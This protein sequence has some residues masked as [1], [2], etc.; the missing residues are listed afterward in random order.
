MYLSKL[1]LKNFRKYRELEIP[2]KEGLN[3][4]IG[5]NDSGKTAIID[6]IRILM[7]TQSY[8]YYFIDE[9]DFN[10][11][12]KE[13]EIECTFSFKKESNDKVAKFLEWI[14]FNEK[15]EPKLIVRLKASIKDFKVKKVITAGEEGLDSRF[16][17]LDDLRVTYLKPLRDA[18]TELTAGR[19]SRLSQILKNHK[20]FVNQE[21]SHTF[22]DTIKSFNEE[23]NSYFKTGG[24]GESIISNINNHLDDFL[25]KERLADYNTDINITEDNL[26]SI[27]N[28]LNL[29]ISKNK[30]GLGTL[31]QLYMAL[32]L[33]LFETEN[34]PLNLCLIE[35]LEAHLHPQAQLRTI[36]HFQN[37]LNENSQII[38]TTHSIN[39]AS[40][41]KLE[42][43]ILCKNDNVYPMGKD[44]TELDTDDYE[45]LEIFLD[46]TKSN[47]FFAK[48][49][50]FVEGDAE[51]I[52]VPAIAEII[53]RPLHEYGVSIVNIGNV[54]FK[55]YSRIFLRKKSDE[56]IGIKVAII[57]DLDVKEIS[58]Y[59]GIVLNDEMLSRINKVLEQKGKNIDDFKDGIF[60]DEEELIEN[61]KEKIGIKRL[62][63]GIK[64]IIKNFEIVDI[65]I[66]IYRE[67]IKQR[68]EKI[69]NKSNIKV[70]LN[71]CQ[72]LEYDLAMSKI[73]YYLNNAILLTKEKEELTEEKFNEEY[74]K[75]NIKEK[76]RKIFI[77]NFYTNYEENK[78]SNLS[79]AN[80]ALNLSYILRQNQENVR[81]ILLKDDYCKY[82][83][84][85]I[86][87]VTAPIER[88]EIR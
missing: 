79:K 27:L 74:G 72:T 7:G 71:K 63:S 83:V 64:E 18:N 3:V 24:A 42:N 36:K 78:K 2:F 85:A 43:L 68:K 50:I 48:G 87:Y 75:D 6:S 51:N 5:E 21:N 65:D 12:N 60:R 66:E 17:L 77:E 35:E 8:E 62:Y 44:Y 52:L 55:R 13:L 84:D 86:E 37:K 61:I 33:L 22:L 88:E 30:V 16:D 45:F 58:N 1:K 76:A 26:S 56:D 14:T 73:A 31:N 9:K 59:K 57:T 20:L 54:A 29:K 67:I 70:F 49:V 47:L 46:A 10:D 4:L 15:K 19:F 40:S 81:K 69:Y 41:I 39:L 34:N 11:K 38:L 28:S 82:L 32:E 80:V 23:I 25:G 53:G